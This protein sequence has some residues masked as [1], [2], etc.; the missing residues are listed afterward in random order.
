MAHDNEAMTVPIFV[1]IPV[2]DDRDVPAPIFVVIPVVDY[3]D[4]AITVMVMVSLADVHRNP[5]VL[6]HNHCVVG[7]VRSRERGSV[8]KAI[9]PIAKAILF[10][11]LPPEVV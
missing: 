1:A 2:A 8:K 10:M 11:V 5:F 7:A 3:R 4:M 6:S 9:A